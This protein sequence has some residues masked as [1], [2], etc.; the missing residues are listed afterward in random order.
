MNEAG[1]GASAERNARW[2]DGGALTSIAFLVDETTVLVCGRVEAEPPLRGTILAATNEGDGEWRCYPW[3]CRGLGAGW[4]FAAVV[5]SSAVVRCLLAEKSIIEEGTGAAFTLPSFSR[6]TPDLRAVVA[7]LKG[8]GGDC[9]HVAEFL[10]ETLL[11][12]GE[13][14]K[15]AHAFLRDF[16]DALADKDGFVEVLGATE[17]GAVLIQGWSTHLQPGHHRVILIANGPRPAK[18][19]VGTFA[20]SDIPNGAAGIVILVEHSEIERPEDLGRVYYSAPDGY[21][22][23]DALTDQCSVL[24]C[25]ETAG[26]IR[27]MLPQLTCGAASRRDFERMGQAC[28]QGKDTVCALTIPVRLAIDFAVHVQGTGFFLSGWLLDPERRVAGVF[29]KSTQNFYRPL[30]GAWVRRPRPDLDAVFQTDPVFS[31]TVT[32]GDSDHGFMVFAPVPESPRAREAFYL[33]IAFKDGAA[34]FMPIVFEEGAAERQ[35]A[36][37]FGVVDSTHVEIDRLIR[38]HIGPIASALAAARPRPAAAFTR[39]P[40][41]T[42]LPS[43]SVSVIVP[44]RGDPADMEVLLAC[45]SR[46]PDFAN[47]E[48]IFIVH[49]ASAASAGALL[50]RRGVF[51]GLAGELLVHDDPLDRAAQLD[52]GMLAAEAPCILWMTPSVLPRAS[53]WLGR[54]IDMLA[55]LP[56][57][58]TLSPTLIYEDF[59]I[60]YAGDGEEHAG[61][62][63][64]AKGTGLTGYPQHRI[65]QASDPVPA[66]P[67]LDCC[68]LPRGLGQ[69]VGGLFGGLLGGEW[70]SRDF[71]NRL[72]QAGGECYWAP[73]ISLYALDDQSVDPQPSHAWLAARIDGWSFNRRWAFGRPISVMEAG[74]RIE[75]GR[76]S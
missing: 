50:C 12:G 17:S 58:A 35:L 43:P 57:K 73:Q 54:M 41:G 72:R 9:G 65:E 21:F 55:A 32:P 68:L 48:L 62:F 56:A 10:V 76:A 74:T 30:D 19:V 69:E 28:F 61:A 44:V 42:S 26:H 31:Q 2:W 27:K 51:Y 59:S 39:I 46:D 67:T 13:A 60:R 40:F 45:F 23:L 47:A 22:R 36:L 20:R 7:W 49:K 3:P 18:A 24:D 4:L 16:L 11:E 34:A 14:G 1:P 15:G 38:S 70:I 63:A 64:A 66:V 71:T 37:I 75:A 52:L 6:M 8:S 29:I 5:T 53:G 33:E 25:S